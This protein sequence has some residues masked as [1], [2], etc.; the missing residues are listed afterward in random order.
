MDRLSTEPFSIERAS[1]KSTF[2]K[3]GAERVG[4]S[5]ARAMMGIRNPLRKC[6]M[7]E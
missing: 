6:I 5:I 7:K 3:I 2:G 4:D 1:N